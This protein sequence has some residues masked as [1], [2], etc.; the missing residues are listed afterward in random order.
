MLA[1]H[2]DSA[3]IIQKHYIHFGSMVHSRLPLPYPYALI[4]HENYQ[5]AEV[6]KETGSES[7]IAESEEKLF[8]GVNYVAFDC[9]FLIICTSNQINEVLRNEKS[10]EIKYIIYTFGTGKSYTFADEKR[11]W[12]KARQINFSGEKKLLNLDEYNA[13][14][15]DTKQ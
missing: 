15:Y 6:V 4:I 13:L 2:D 5:S 9:R 10:E 12:E 1:C 14:F 7:G 3:G 11:M 8:L